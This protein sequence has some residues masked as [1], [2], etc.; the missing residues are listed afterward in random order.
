M[1]A[2]LK[3]FQK[4]AGDDAHYAAVA[5]QAKKLDDELGSFRDSIY[6]PGVQ[7]DVVEDDLKQLSDLHGGLEAVAGYG[8]SGL[9]GQM[10][11]TSLLDIAH[12]LETKAAA[13]VARFN[14]LLRGDVANYNQA[15]YAAGAP[16]L[17]TGEP[18]TTKAS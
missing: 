10:P 2:S 3:Q 14:Q 12:E 13:K 7:H 18:V 4:T 6:A 1:R 8:F 11:P 15:A 9:Q 5:A 17:M 16:T